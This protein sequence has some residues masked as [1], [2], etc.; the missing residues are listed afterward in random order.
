MT[1]EDLM[2]AMATNLASIT[3]RTSMGVIV[4]GGVVCPYELCVFNYGLNA[5]LKSLEKI[6][7]LKFLK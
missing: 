5:S 7:T 1:Q 3:S 2:I 6:K 4:V